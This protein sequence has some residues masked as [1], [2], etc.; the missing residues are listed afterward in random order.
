MYYPA[1]FPLLGAMAARTKRIRLGTYIVALPLYHPLQIAEQAATL[2]ALSD[3]RFD[4]GLGIGNFVRDFDTYKVSRRERGAR[5]EEGLAI[6]T[7]LWT[8]QDF[9]FDGKYYSVPPTTLFPRPVQ[10]RPPLWVAATVERAFDR[11]AR[12]QAHLAGTGTG[13]EYYEQRLQHYGHDPR[14]FHKG[15]LEFYHLADTVDAAW[16]A[17]A[18]GIHHFLEYYDREFSAHDDFKGLKAALG[19]T[20]FG[21]DPLPAAAELQQVERLHFLGSP[22]VVG[23]AEDAIADI[24][25]A[26]DEGA[27]DMVMQMDL[28]GL[29]PRLVE[30]SMRIFASEVMPS[31]R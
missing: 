17:A 25:R 26:R 21:V 10:I 15:I 14:E 31:F 13:F 6:I 1:Q 27:T 8:Q 4:L 2:D 11:A 19:G 22:F 24:E 18:P 23:T 29:D 16:R 5:M 28:A 3:G 9:S 20:F 30:R 7:G 12:Y